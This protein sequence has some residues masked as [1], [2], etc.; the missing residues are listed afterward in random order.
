[1]TVN[2]SVTPAVSISAS[3]N[4]ICAGTN[5]TFTASPTNEGSSPTYQWQLNGSN[6]G[7]S[8]TTY[9]N[10]GLAD[11]DIVSCVLTSSETCTSTNPVTSNN[12]TM[13]VN[14]TVTPT[15]SITVTDSS[16]CTGAI[17]TFT[18]NG[19]NGGS[20]PTYQ[21]KLNGTNVGVSSTTY[22]NSSLTNGDIVSCMLTSSETCI[23][24][25]TA[26]SNN[27]TMTVN[28]IPSSPTTNDE[29]AC[30]GSTIPSLTSTGTNIEWYNNSS[31]T[32]LVNTGNTYATGQTNAGTYTYY[33][34]E[35]NNGCKS[36]AVT[37]TLT[38]TQAI[39]P[40]INYDWTCGSGSVT[41]TASGQGTIYWYTS[42]TGG[43]PIDSGS[44]FNTPVIN[45]TTNYYAESNLNGCVS[46]SRGLG[47]AIVYHQPT[48]NFS[49]T[50]NI[51]DVSFT[52][53]STNS[54]TYFW[55]FG[56]N[57]TSNAI[58]PLHTYAQEQVYNVMLVA[59]NPCYVDTIY[60]IVDLSPVGMFAVSGNNDIVIYPNPAKTYL[61][62]KSS[63]N[64]IL[65][66]DIYNIYGQKIK[67]LKLDNTK[68]VI[69]IKTLSKG[70]YLIKLQTAKGTL[71]KKIIKE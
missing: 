31:L 5:V 11:G 33:V 22:S 14:A 49:Y 17:V 29:D 68:A 64:N 35:N 13:I 59:E 60:K 48:A 34:I 47:L 39:T 10:S 50:A 16:I 1:M 4:N 8:S 57:S 26:N 3:D 25:S 37:A 28:T 19:T 54:D 55:D 71:I 46:N 51:L 58:N 15:I 9:S 65:N 63:S 61:Q 23:T 52:N 24:S 30:Y 66:I 38:I 45:Y 7:A 18:A 62:I 53:N 32:N 67:Q 43:T 40:I 20:T 2:S 42:L 27:I 6:V 12:I 21:W 56:D 41:L 69:D 36:S 70:V 44:A